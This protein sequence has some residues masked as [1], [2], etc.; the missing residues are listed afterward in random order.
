MRKVP[1]DDG[2]FCREIEDWEATGQEEMEQL[3]K[4]CQQKEKELHKAI[5][6]T[7]A[8]KHKHNTPITYAEQKQKPSVMDVRDRLNNLQ[9][10]VD[11]LHY[12][13]LSDES[14]DPQRKSANVASVLYCFVQEQL[15]LA[16]KELA[17]V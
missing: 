3:L 7:I 17:E 2:S 6:E 1:Y 4:S 12:A 10:L 16:E 5:F 13:L 9:C 8:K 11:V 14:M 15:E